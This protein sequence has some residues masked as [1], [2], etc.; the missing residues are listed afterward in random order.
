LI[1][2]AVRTQE[3]QQHQKA[4]PVKPPSLTGDSPASNLHGL[5]MVI[6]PEVQIVT[7]SLDR[8]GNI[9]GVGTVHSESTER[10]P[11]F[12]YARHYR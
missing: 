11:T 3:K 10:R 7:Y 2:A 5:Y 12:D 4:L 6:A 1:E 8:P 9:K